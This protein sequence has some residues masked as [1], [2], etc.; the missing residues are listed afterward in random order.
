[1]PTIAHFSKLPFFLPVLLTLFLP[2][3][4][5]ADLS[6]YP[7]AGE[8][9]KRF[10]IRLPEMDLIETK[11]LEILV[12]RTEEL[13]ETNRYFFP[14]KLSEEPV[15]GYGFTYY[16]L[17]EVGP[18]AGTKMA[19]PPDAPKSQ[20][21]IYVQGG[22]PLLAYNNDLPYVVIVPEGFQVEYRIWAAAMP[23][24]AREG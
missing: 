4:R 9:E 6:A 20:R 7:E 22:L 11:K 1:M 5:G 15:E 23:L 24:A 3:L 16:R 21:K 14:G 19:P 17:S 18:L 2:A 10:V 12:F 8:G 13:D